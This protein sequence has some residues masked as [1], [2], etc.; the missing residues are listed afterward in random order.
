M[1]G[2]TGNTGKTIHQLTLE[3]IAC[4]RNQS[5]ERFHLYLDEDVSRNDSLIKVDGMKQLMKAAH[6]KY[7]ALQF[8]IA[9]LVVDEEKGLVCARLILKG[10]ELHGEVTN[11][12]PRDHIIYQW[13]EGKIKEIWSVMADMDKM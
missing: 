12:L 8:G 13:R 5:Y 1:S 6:A 2:F 9:L 3:Y 10:G 4:L 7:P 11:R